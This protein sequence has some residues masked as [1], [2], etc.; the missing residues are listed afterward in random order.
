MRTRFV[1]G[2]KILAINLA[3]FEKSENRIFAKKP[4][5]ASRKH[6]ILLYFTMPHVL[7]PSLSTGQYEGVRT[8]THTVHCIAVYSICL[9]APRSPT[10]LPHT[11]AFP[12]KVVHDYLEFTK[13]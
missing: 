5:I 8:N 9:P 10:L 2:E 6:N 11:P 12:G 3:A 13:L 7:E 1:S 4:R